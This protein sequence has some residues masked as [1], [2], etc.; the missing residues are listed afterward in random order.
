MTLIHERAGL[1]EDLCG[2]MHWGSY[3]QNLEIKVEEYNSF[4]ETA[5]TLT[6]PKARQ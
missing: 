1:E 3:G 2:V 4:G 5:Y 6:L